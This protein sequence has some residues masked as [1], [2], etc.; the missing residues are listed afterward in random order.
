MLSK[1][2]LKLVKSLQIKKYRQEHQ[3][4]LVEGKKSVLELAHSNFV[5][6]TIFCTE[7]FQEQYL[8]NSNLKYEDLQIATENELASLGSFDT[9]NTVIALVKMPPKQLKTYEN[10]FTLVLDNVQDPGNLGTIIRTADWFGVKQIICSLTTV[11][12]FNPKVIAASMGSFT[13]VEMLYEDL[14]KVLF[15]FKSKKYQIYGAYMNGENLKTINATEKLVL[16]MGNEANGI[17][18]KYLPFIDKKISIEGK[19]NTESLNVSI[20]C[21]IILYQIT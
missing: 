3:L 19:G 21:A 11:D 7:A 10:N 5:I 15:D 12:V 2:T 16:I 14:E 8:T 20:A 9:N 6:K 17:S 4:F 18:E 1:N 13:R